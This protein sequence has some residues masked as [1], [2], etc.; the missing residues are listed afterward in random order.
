MFL[1]KHN[2]LYFW[3]LAFRVCLKALGF[4]CPWLQQAIFKSFIIRVLVWLCS[5]LCKTA[6]LFSL[7]L[8]SVLF[9]FLC[10]ARKKLWKCLPGEM[11]LCIVVNGLAAAWT[12]RKKKTEQKSQ[13]IRFLAS[14]QNKYILSV[15]F[16]W[17]YNKS[18]T[19]ISGVFG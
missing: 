5:G 10:F 12:K 15:F 2:L 18:V 11:I 4:A 19:F 1:F 9:H 16:S 13:M 6:F 8:T 7:P 3:S 17:H 14:L